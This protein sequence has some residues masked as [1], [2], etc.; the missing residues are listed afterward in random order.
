MSQKVKTDIE[1]LTLTSTNDVSDSKIRWDKNHGKFIHEYTFKH[2]KRDLLNSVNEFVHAIQNNLKAFN[3]KLK[4]SLTDI[5]NDLEAET[6]RAER[7][8]AGLASDISDETTRAKEAEGGLATKISQETS[9]AERAEAGLASD[10][11]DL[12]NEVEALKQK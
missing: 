3:A 2:Y 7:A 9:R 8:E 11:S 10:I 5:N 4:T 1:N 6:N 12:R